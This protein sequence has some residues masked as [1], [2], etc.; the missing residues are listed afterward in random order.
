MPYPKVSRPPDLRGRRLA[1]AGLRE[2]LVQ[3]GPLPVLFSHGASLSS[4]DC[5]KD[6]QTGLAKLTDGVLGSISC[7]AT[8]KFWGHSFPMPLLNHHEFPDFT[9][10]LFIIL[11]KFY[12]FLQ[13]LKQVSMG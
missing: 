6:K 1:E 5:R 8:Y 7:S 10:A 4:V 12:S 2:A 13:T 3:F 11:H 9:H